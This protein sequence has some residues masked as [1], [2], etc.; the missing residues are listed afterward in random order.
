MKFFYPE[1]VLW[2]NGEIYS[3][4]VIFVQDSGKI[5]KILPFDRISSKVRRQIQY[6]KGLLIPGMVNAHSHMELSWLKG[7]IPQGLG[8]ESFF[9]HM[10]GVHS[11]R[12]QEKDVFEMIQKSIAEMYSKG[13]QICA[14]ISNTGISYLAKE[15]SP[16]LFHT[17]VEVFEI[18]GFSR[19][20]I[21]TNAEKTFAKFADSHQNSS[22]LSLHTLFTS[23]NALIKELMHKIEK[24]N[25][26]H[27]L[28]FMERN[29]ENLFYSEGRPLL[30]IHEKQ[31]PKYNSDRPAEIAAEVLPKESRTLLVHNTFCSERDIIE[32]VDYFSD[33][34]FCLCP[35]SNIFINDA[36]P[37]IYDLMKHSDNIVLGTDSYASN[38]EMNLFGEMQILLDKFDAIDFGDLLKMA[39]ING[40]KLLGLEKTHGSISPGKKPGLILIR[41][42]NPDDRN[43]KF[44]DI[45]RLF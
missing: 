26:L 1:Y 14:D 22:S 31:T 11:K 6:L 43:I 15:H 27:S 45:R 16:M 24:S 29:E 13:I 38:T 10:K 17:F 41:D 3:G 12:P 32:L 34:W 9:S 37:P 44:Q 42:Y 18:E 25:S 35:S 19:E 23:S 40:A 8:M 7:Q 21:L 33:V 5:H 39:T 4:F 28:H 2:E 20:N 36:L 30:S